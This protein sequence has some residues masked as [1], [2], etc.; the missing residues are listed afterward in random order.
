MSNDRRFTVWIMGNKNNVDSFHVS[1]VRNKDEANIDKRPSAAI[2]PVSMLYDEDLQSTRAT[3]F[4]EYLNSLLDAA[5]VAE[6][7]IHLVDILKR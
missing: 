7:Q 3:K 1:D 6:E 2:F 4:A 5:K